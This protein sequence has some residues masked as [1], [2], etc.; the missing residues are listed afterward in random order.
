MPTRI[1]THKKAPVDALV[2]LQAPID[3]RCPHHIA[4]GRS[5]AW[6]GVVAA[7]LS[8]P[9]DGNDLQWLEDALQAHSPRIR[10]DERLPGGLR[11]L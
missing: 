11:D 6:Q 8:A 3:G 7:S 1:W 2:S 5:T 10:D 9:L 4:W